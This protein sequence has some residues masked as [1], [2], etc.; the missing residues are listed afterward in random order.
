[1]QNI[2]RLFF[3]FF[4][5]LVTGGLQPVY[6]QTHTHNLF[7]ADSLFNKGKYL[8]VLTVYKKILEEGREYSP[9]MLLNMAYTEEALNRFTQPMYYLNQYYQLLPSRTVL[10]KMEEVAIANGLVGY[11]YKDSDFFITQF[12]KYYFKLLEFLLILA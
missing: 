4:F 7:F 10:K 8:E 11:T 12:R 3:L 9:K 5:I 2:L 6:S 1:M